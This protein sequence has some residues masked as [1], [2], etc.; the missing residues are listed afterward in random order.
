MPAK[1]K[2]VS[3][4]KISPPAEELVQLVEAKK[5]LPDFKRPLR[6]KKSL[7]P[8]SPHRSFRRTYRRDYAR[9]LEM[10]GYFAFTIEVWRILKH[11]GSTFGKLI[12]V[13][14]VVSGF[15]VGLASQSIYSQ[16][17]EL[18]RTTSGEVFEGSIG[19]VGE[20]GLLLVTGISGGINPAMSEVQQ[21]MS[22][23]L[24][25]FVW[26]TT[27]WLLR[28]F[29]AE[30]KPRL[31]DGFYNA[32][33]P[34]IPTLLLSLVLILQLIPAAIAAIGISAAMPTGLISQ[35]VEAMLFWV[36]VL[37]LLLLSLFWA[38]STLIALV[39]IT[40]PGMYPLRALKSAHE[41][42]VGR[43]LPIVLRIVWLAIVTIILWAV[44]LIPIIL[45]DAW[46]KGLW[47][48]IDAIPIVPVALLLA[49]TA[50]VVWAASYIYL[51]YRKV[52]DDDSAP[53]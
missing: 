30:H 6:W 36:V 23:L 2:V 21:L 44:V 52:V 18:L 10:P 26:L 48:V 29:L 24:V 34:F 7:Q 1:K 50:S 47:P 39:I 3:K 45:L 11:H 53:A 33:A 46:I 40:L 5:K 42:V 9:S 17:S 22:G 19:K 38:T 16:L 13:Y 43:R 20:A 8:R 14:A 37:L 35:G 4:K 31:K 12:A 15:L 32:G 27:V 49:S 25:L 51:L 41:L 28:A